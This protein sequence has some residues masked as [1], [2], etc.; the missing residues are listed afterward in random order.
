MEAG[1][2]R[3]TAKEVEALRRKEK[4]LS[5]EVDRLTVSSAG[6][7]TVVEER[8]SVLQGE[9]EGAEKKLQAHQAHSAKVKETY[10]RLT[11]MYNGVRDENIELQAK[12][13]DLEAKAA[14]GGGGDS[15]GGASH[16]EL[17]DTKNDLRNCRKDLGDTQKDLASTRK[18]LE[19][20]RKELRQT[21]QAVRDVE[22]SKSALERDSRQMKS[23]LGSLQS[24]L[25]VSVKDLNAAREEMDNVAAQLSETT[26]ERDSLMAKSGGQKEQRSVDEGKL[27]EATKARGASERELARTRQKVSELERVVADKTDDVEY[28]KQ[29]KNKAREER[30]ALRESARALERRTSQVSQTADAVHSLKRQLSTHKMREADQSAMIKDLRE[31]MDRIQEEKDALA[32]KMREMPPPVEPMDAEG[33]EDNASVLEELVMAKLSLATLEDE[34][35]NLEFKTK[36]QR[37]GEKAIQEKLAAHASSLEVRLGEASDELSKLRMNSPPSPSYS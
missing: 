20:S 34:M 6:G 21:Q 10:V 9:K 23:Q 4:E 31:E 11:G 27:A 32:K 22:D 37:K 30:D 1:E 19:E 13:D 14:S 15:G 18:D 29:E 8:L 25:D 35:L 7:D 36:Q 17:A 16:Q 26:A 5:R 2:L 3:A 24:R 33:T 12:V 28:E